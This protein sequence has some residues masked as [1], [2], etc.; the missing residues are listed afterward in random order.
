MAIFTGDYRRFREFGGCCTRAVTGSS[1]VNGLISK[2][3]TRL[4]RTI[5]AEAQ[6][7]NKMRA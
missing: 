1:G 6:K 3:L 7:Q 4:H 2:N 5:A